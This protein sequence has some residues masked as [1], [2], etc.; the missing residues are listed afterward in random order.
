MKYLVLA[1]LA[2]CYADS[3]LE[4]TVSGPEI[5]SNAIEVDSGCPDCFPVADGVTPV[6]MRVCTKADHRPAS[7]D[8]TLKTSAGSWVGAGGMATTTVSLA[9]GPCATASLIP[10]TT[11]GTVLIQATVGGLS[12]TKAVMLNPATLAFVAMNP[13]PAT[14]T[15]TTTSVVVTA[16]AN[17]T[18]GGT[19][20][21][22]T[23][24]FADVNAIDPVGTAYE[25]R[26]SVQLVDA[27]GGGAFTLVIP[28]NVN[29]VAYTVHASVCLDSTCSTTEE[30]AAVQ[31]IFATP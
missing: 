1:V 12:I 25:F 27:T 31:T 4:T 14:L 22:G 18:T 15:K 28:P 16:K 17:V 7:L 9:G 26:P 21:L 6:E 30:T 2:G 11:P 5:T 13:I 29:A 3:D 19:A 10:N 20:S 8:V 23:K 24:L